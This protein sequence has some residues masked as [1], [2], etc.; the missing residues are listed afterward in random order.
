MFNELSLDN[1][2]KFFFTNE[3]IPGLLN[4]KLK[5]SFFISSDKPHN[6]LLNS[7][8]IMSA[9]ILLNLVHPDMKMSEKFDFVS[10]YIK[11]IAG[12]EFLRYEKTKIRGLFFIHLLSQNL[13]VNV[14]F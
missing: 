6:P 2:S 8:A 1:N 9:A 5:F 4:L 7:G 10:D 13:I 14:L 11:R 3:N 12:D